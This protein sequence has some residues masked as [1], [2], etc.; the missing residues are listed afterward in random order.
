MQ[1]DG[2]GGVKLAN[3]AVERTAGSH[4]LA[5]AAHRWSYAA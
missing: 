1:V 2:R 3:L 4:A 5:A